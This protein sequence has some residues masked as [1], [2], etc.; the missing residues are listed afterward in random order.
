M[1]LGK[2]TYTSN[3]VTVISFFSFS[4]LGGCMKWIDCRSQS[5][6]LAATAFS[7]I[8][9]L[10]L[11]IHPYSIRVGGTTR[12]QWVDQGQT[13]LYSDP[14]SRQPFRI[15]L[16][17]FLDMIRQ[18][19]DNAKNLYASFLPPGYHSPTMNVSDLTDNGL[20]GQSIFAQPS[21]RAIFTPLAVAFYDAAIADST[22][23]RQEFHRQEQELLQGLLIAVSMTIGIP[24]RAFQLAGMLY[25][26]SDTNGQKRSLYIKK[27]VVVLGWARAAKSLRSIYQA[28]FWALPGDLGKIILNYLGVIR[29]ASIKLLQ[30]RNMDV[31]K[32]LNTHIF[33]FTTSL[34]SKSS[35]WPGTHISAILKA[36]TGSKIN[37]EM[38]PARLRQLMTAVYRK[39]F[40]AYIQ[41]TPFPTL[42]YYKAGHTTHAAPNNAFHDF[43]GSRV[44]TSDESVSRHIGVSQVWQG[45][46][47]MLP[48]MCGFFGSI[49]GP[50]DKQMRDG[51]ASALDRARWLIYR[52]FVGLD[53]TKVR[54]EALNMLRDRSFMSIPF[55]PVRA[56]HMS[57]CLMITHECTG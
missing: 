3:I 24:P 22:R 57:G 15:R 5:K 46:L 51:R 2:C 55:E 10:W 30:S 54:G 38:S 34:K 1:N 27:G 31:H 18:L 50:S 48:N 29:P 49:R 12:V 13:L 33:A 19:V 9:L 56:I 20:L 26:A 45:V 8:K 25:E 23:S 41:V 47:G 7:K 28:S 32:D 36:A 17:S 14:G 42:I 6:H 35:A 53:A 11:I 52:S 16:S 40:P 37:F 21:N 39:H 4:V 43:F 44:V